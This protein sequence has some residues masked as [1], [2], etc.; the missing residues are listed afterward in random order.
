MYQ[1]IVFQIIYQ[2]I[3]TT[4]LAFVVIKIYKK[5]IW[6]IIVL[7]FVCVVFFLCQ[8]IYS[9][10]LLKNHN[11][12]VGTITGYSNK[13]KQGSSWGY[14]FIHKEIVYN[15]SVSVPIWSNVNKE[16]IK[17]GQ[18]YEV[19]VLPNSPSISEIDLTKPIK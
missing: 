9:V 17:E 11:I 13:V 4:L 8:L 10:L 14:K 18:K 7:L 16:S 6:S 1:N 19:W 2:S 12:V 5:K 3:I 15:N